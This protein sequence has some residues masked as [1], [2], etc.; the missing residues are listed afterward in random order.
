MT[1]DADRV[2]DLQ[3]RIGALAKALDVCLDA[4]IILWGEDAAEQIELLRDQLIK[5]FKTTG[6]PAERELDHA[7]VVGPAIEVLEE[8]FNDALRRCP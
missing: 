1:N 5:T 3:S 2:Q 6:I 8:V 4:L 7:K